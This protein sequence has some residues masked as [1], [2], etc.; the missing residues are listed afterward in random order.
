VTRENIELGHLPLSVEAG[1]VNTFGLK[2]L[3]K[4]IDLV[5]VFSREQA[6]S[7]IGMEDEIFLIIKLYDFNLRLVSCGCEERRIAFCVRDKWNH[8]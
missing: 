6:Y 7:K 4:L 8:I 2:V 3:M 5:Y 1:Q